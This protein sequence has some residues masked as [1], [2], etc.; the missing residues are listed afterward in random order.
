MKCLG[1]SVTSLVFLPVLL[2]NRRMEKRGLC[3]AEQQGGTWKRLPQTSVLPSS[4]ALS[5]ECKAP[6]PAPQSHVASAD[7]QWCSSP[8]PIHTLVALSEHF[9]HRNSEGVV[10]DLQRNSL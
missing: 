5:T 3:T 2:L 6:S 1:V 7:A 8:V 10:C 4:Q 9:Y